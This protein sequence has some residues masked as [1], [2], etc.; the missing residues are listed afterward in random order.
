MA[1]TKEYEPV[2]S[3]QE[4][5][6]TDPTARD[7]FVDEDTDDPVEGFGVSD[8]EYGNELDKL[9]LDE[10]S[11]EDEDTYEDDED[12][13]EQTEDLDEDLGDDTKY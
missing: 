3:Y 9:A 10:D 1:G 5:L 2:H 6:E 12:L 8:E 4:D 11:L 7:P 13:R